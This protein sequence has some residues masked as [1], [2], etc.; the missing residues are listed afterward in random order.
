LCSA[1]SLS[2]KHHLD[3]ISSRPVSVSS[4][5]QTIASDTSTHSHLT[6]STTSTFYPTTHS[7]MSYNRQRC[8]ALHRL[9]IEQLPSIPTTSERSQVRISYGYD[10]PVRTMPVST[11]LYHCTGIDADGFQGPRSPLSELPVQRPDGVGHSRKEMP[12]V[13]LRGELSWFS[14]Y[15]CLHHL[16][17]DI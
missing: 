7:K 17:A 8:E 15:G 3:F 10:L 13:R 2:C 4:I 6:I 14:W 5:Q 1:S 9:G 12:P 16:S 11:R